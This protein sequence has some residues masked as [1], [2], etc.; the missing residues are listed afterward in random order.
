AIA[1]RRIYGAIVPGGRRPRVHVL[2]SEGVDQGVGRARLERRVGVEPGHRI[3]DDRDL[4]GAG[5]VAEVVHHDEGAQ[6][7]RGHRHVAADPARAIAAGPRAPGPTAGAGA[8]GRG[9]ARARLPAP[10][11]ASGGLPPAPRGAA[12]AVS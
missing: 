7:L 12:R 5:A 9:T 2:A 4:A 3:A 1:R 11:A 6:R 8:A 10:A